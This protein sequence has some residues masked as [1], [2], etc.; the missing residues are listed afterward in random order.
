MQKH[1]EKVKVLCNDRCEDDKEETVFRE[2]PVSMPRPGKGLEGINGSAR[3]SLRALNAQC[4]AECLA[5][6]R[7][8]VNA[9]VAHF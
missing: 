4:S 5:H 2:L 3:S 8:T 9:C 1:L 6:R 7:H